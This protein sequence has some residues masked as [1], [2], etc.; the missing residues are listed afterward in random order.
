MASGAVPGTKVFLVHGQDGDTKQQV[1]TFLEGILGERPVILHEQP[2][3]GRTLIEKFEDH[4]AEVGFAVVLLTSDDVGAAKEER[5][6]NPR[7]RQ[8]VVF[9][10]GFFVAKLGRGRVVAIHEEGVEL[11]SDLD[12][13]LYQPLDGDWQMGLARELEGAGFSVDLSAAL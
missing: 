9:E 12:G 3:R 10:H 5:T 11:P 1:A 2:N 7:A 4:A 8:N 6:H 13:V